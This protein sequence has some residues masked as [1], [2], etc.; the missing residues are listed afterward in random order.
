MGMLQDERLRIRHAHTVKVSIG[1][2]ALAEPAPSASRQPA[3]FSWFGCLPLEWISISTGGA[4]ADGR[5]KYL[6]SPAN[7]HA[8]EFATGGSCSSEISAFG[9]SVGREGSSLKG[10]L[11][12]GAADYMNRAQGL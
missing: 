2:T 8:E 12:I 4:S 10:P 11:S 1:G 6:S 9:K 7:G 3:D 5:A